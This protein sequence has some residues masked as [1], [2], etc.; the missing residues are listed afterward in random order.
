MA[1][2]PAG[3]A[4]LPMLPAGRFAA[5]HGA[6]FLFGAALLGANVA[7]MRMMHNTVVPP[8]KKSEYLALRYAA[9]GLVAGAVPLLAGS[10][11]GW[12]EGLA[13]RWHGLPVSAWLPL[14]GLCSL[15]WAGSAALFGS[16]SEDKPS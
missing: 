8:E 15:A 16:I 1:A 7:A 2:M 14:F 9:V 12:F 4:A 10:S 11:L 13:G 5:A 3:W 6:Y